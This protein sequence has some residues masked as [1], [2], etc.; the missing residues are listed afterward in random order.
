MRPPSPWGQWCPPG[1]RRSSVVVLVLIP[2]ATTALPVNHNQDSPHQRDRPHQDHL[3]PPRVR[4]GYST[5]RV[6]P[7]ILKGY[8]IQPQNTLAAI[9]T[10]NSQ[11][12]IRFLRLYTFVSKKP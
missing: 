9:L 4:K 6:R 10:K 12:Y 7:R 11:G 5:F 8:L 3:L 1:M 2:L